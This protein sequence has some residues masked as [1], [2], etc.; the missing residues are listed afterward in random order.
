MIIL[1]YVLGVLAVIAMI[2][3]AG[4]AI[5]S[6][7][8]SAKI[9]KA[10]P[11]CGKVTDVA[12]GKIHAF[13]A[14]SGRSILMIHGLA[15]NLLN[16]RYA[17]MDTL[18]DDYRIVAIDR[19]GCG[20]SERDSDERARLPHQAAMIAEFIDKAGLDRPLVVGHSLGGA[21]S[22][23]LA[24]NHPDKV[25]GLALIAPLTTPPESPPDIFTGLNIAN[26]LRRKFIAATLAIPSLLRNAPKITAGIF[27]PDSVPEDFSERG[28]G[29]LTV[30][31]DAFY[32]AS[33]DL[34]ASIVD[35]DD[36]QARYSELNVPVGMLYGDQDNVLRYD[37][38]VAAVQSA[39]SKLQLKVLEGVGHMPLVTQPKETVGF[40][41]GMAEQ[42]LT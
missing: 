32:T 14:G 22:L 15:G 3:L 16:F 30:P 40:I 18:T 35:L 19:P 17:C 20:Y 21:V 10:L 12:N 7:S 4:A 11:P 42:C 26:P 9:Y 28:G 39:Y 38:H 6:R 33:T 27:A 8:V 36:V 24:L 25:S 5:F 1:L 34:H 41:R 13:E 37:V 31:S 23:A 2:G 29:I